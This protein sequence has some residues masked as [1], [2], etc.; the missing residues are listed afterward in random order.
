MWQCMG[1]GIRVRLYICFY[2]KQ[3]PKLVQVLMFIVENED[4]CSKLFIFD[5]YVGKLASTSV[6]GKQQ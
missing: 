3:S 5:I 4:M 6:T 2:S 1:M